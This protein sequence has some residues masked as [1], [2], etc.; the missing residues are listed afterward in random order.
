MSTGIDKQRVRRAFSRAAHRYDEVAVLQ[1]EVGDRMMERLDLVKLQPRLVLDLGCGTG[2]HSGALLRRY[3]KARLLALDLALPMLQC[4]RRR[5][6]W[7]RRPVCLCGDMERLPL[8]SGSIDLLWSNL[9][10]QW[11]SDPGALFRECLRVLRPGGLLMFTTFGPGTL[12]ELR[13]AWSE[14]DD[15]QHVS[16]FIDMHDLGDLLLHTGFAEPV[17]DVDRLQ[18]TYGQVDDLMRDLKTLGAHN[19]TEGRPRALTGK[20]RMEAM[21]RAYE[22]F[23]R[24]DGLLPAS[25]EVVY[26]H[27]W[28]PE[29][30][31]VEVSLEI[32]SPRPSPGGRGGG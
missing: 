11:S 2:L 13:Q 26:G 25:Y 28:A 31:G 21:R 32:P 10:F 16:P 17:M 1:R 14:V 12:E 5:G 22:A 20:G 3:P 15:R 29:E 24:D 23:R 9:A 27:A 30:R 7:L 6:R 19:A 18:L 4:T 8:A